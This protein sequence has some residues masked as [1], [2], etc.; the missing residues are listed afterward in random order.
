MESFYYQHL[1]VREQK[2][3]DAVVQ[4]IRDRK[5]SA[6]VIGSLKVKEL[7]EDILYSHPELFYMNNA[8]RHSIGL[9]GVTLEL[10]Y[11]YSAAQ[12]RELERELEQ[13]ADEVIRTL[14]NSHQSDYDKVLVLH[15]YLKTT[16]EYDYE[17]LEAVMRVRLASP[18]SSSLIGALLRHKCVC[19]GFAA[20]MKYLCGKAGVE[21]H[22]VTGTGS[23]NVF[24][25]PHAWNIVKINGY[26]QHVDVTW[27]NQT[28]DAKELP[29][30]GYL[31]L[32][33]ETISRDHT[34]NRKNYPKCE[35]DSYNYFRMNDAYI[36][37]KAQLERYLYENLDYEEEYILFKV[38]KGSRLEMEIAGCLEEVFLKAISRCKYTRTEGYSFTMV[39]EQMVYMIKP[40]YAHR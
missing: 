23:S 24:S 18:D 32:D 16:I 27:D 31:N 3:Y 40:V 22:T 38:A 11:T 6:S 25:G 35:N 1:N 28:A 30:Y 34:W 39:P 29:N 7:Y 26:Y 5:R 14:I 20:A 33:D 21:C 8:Y 19:Q 17:G 13:T 10:T 12:S 9:G 37:T 15:D 36:D 2:N 4:A